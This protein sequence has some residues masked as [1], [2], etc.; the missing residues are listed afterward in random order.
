MTK[1]DII[2][3]VVQLAKEFSETS[4]YDLITENAVILR[5]RLTV[6]FKLLGTNE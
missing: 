2:S 3:K 4:G 1:Q 6:L 5:G